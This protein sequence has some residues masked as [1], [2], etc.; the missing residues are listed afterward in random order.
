MP[1]TLNYIDFLKGILPNEFKLFC[2]TDN[3]YIYYVKSC[4]NICPYRD[5]VN[6]FYKWCYNTPEGVN[7]IHWF[8]E[9]KV[10]YDTKYK[11]QT[12]IKQLDRSITKGKKEKKSLGIDHCAYCSKS[13]GYKQIVNKLPC[14]CYI[15]SRCI[16]HLSCKIIKKGEGSQYKLFN[17][18]Y[19]DN[20]RAIYC[21]ECD[22]DLIEVKHPELLKGG[23]LWKKPYLVEY[24]MRILHKILDKKGN[25]DIAEIILGF[26]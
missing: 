24:S 22:V 17:I 8:N 20:S 15:H 2:E 1:L 23:E 14:G 10:E 11:P 4:M 7:F 13:F 26:M 5:D 21:P 9:L 12:L 3:P 18:R 6:E 25:D 19:I 16:F